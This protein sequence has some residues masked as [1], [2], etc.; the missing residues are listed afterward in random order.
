MKSVEK[1][2]TT[3]SE[4]PYVR[5]HGYKALFLLKG[6]ISKEG[7]YSSLQPVLENQNMNVNLYSADKFLF[8][9]SSKTIKVNKNK[10]CLLT[11]VNH[12]N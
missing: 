1:L 8:S 10:Y 7:K 12:N 6:K 11:C 4:I 3:S 5:V 2:S 9:T